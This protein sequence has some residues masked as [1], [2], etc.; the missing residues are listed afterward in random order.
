MI[1]ISQNQIMKD[2]NVDNSNEPLVSIRCITYNHESY[3]SQALDGFLMQKTKFPFEVIVHDDASTDKTAEIIREYEAKYPKII[4][5][6]YEVENQWSKHDGSLA[7]IMKN[8]CKGKYIAV[9]EGDDYWIDDNK[10][11]LQVEFLENNNEYGL[12]Y[13]KSHIYNQL[14]SE[15]TGTM[16]LGK[17]TFNEIFFS[18][19]IPTA[20]MVY[21]K[22]LF[23]KYDDFKNQ[24]GKKW[25]VGDYPLSLWFSLNSKIK[26]FPVITSVY[27]VLEKSASHFKSFSD[28]EKFKFNVYEYIQLFFIETFV[29]DPEEKE[30][31][32]ILI[33]D[34]INRYLCRVALSSKLY[35]KYKCYAKKIKSKRSKDLIIKII[36]S[37]KIFFESSFLIYNLK[38]KRLCR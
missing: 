17:T 5:P 14:A 18:Y 8:A 33:N 9:C 15:M 25:I 27:R 19:D 32:I 20:T 3:I 6:I 28:E 38:Q 10:L 1:D 24:N 23:D 7:R 35:E 21:R 16:G 12:C 2:W 37:N 13:T 11:Q 4:K 30:K 26:F 34:E 22:S 29:K 36:S 31:M